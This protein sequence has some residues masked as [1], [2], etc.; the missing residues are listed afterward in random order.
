MHL[1]RVLVVLVS[2]AAGLRLGTDARSEGLSSPGSQSGTPS[3]APGAQV[4]PQD[5]SRPRKG[6][7]RGRRPKEVEGAKALNRFEAE[8]GLKSRYHIDGKHLEVDTD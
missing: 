2:V 1:T 8:T 4:K 7:K 3:T 5:A 6:S